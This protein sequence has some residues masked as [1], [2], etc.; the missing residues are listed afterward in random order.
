MWAS[1]EV[2]TTKEG[3]SEEYII[4]YDEAEWLDRGDWNKHK[5]KI[6]RG[7]DAKRSG[8]IITIKNLSFSIYPNLSGNVRKDLATRF[9]PFIE[10][11]EARIRVN[12]KW[13]E[14]EPIDLNVEYH[15]PD[16]KEPFR[17]KLESGNE[18]WG[19][20][21]S[22]ERGQKKA[23]TGLGYSDAGDSSCSTRS[24]DLT[25]TRRIGKLSEKSTSTMSR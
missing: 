19:W 3:S 1:F 7:V 15:S 20:R 8:T 14:P 10:T 16:G 24:S 6:K 9:A 17:K 13:C 18:V 11:G 2:R 4:S 21:V 12:T 25:H 5:M 22:C 23:N